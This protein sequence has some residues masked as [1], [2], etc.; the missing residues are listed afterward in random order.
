[1]NTR[2]SIFVA[3]ALT[4]SAIVITANSAI[5]VTASPSTLSDPT[6]SGDFIVSANGYI[7]G[8]GSC[9][10][11]QSAS[12]QAITGP[13][14]LSYSGSA[15]LISDGTGSIP[16]SN[17]TPGSTASGSFSFSQTPAPSLTMFGSAW[18]VPVNGAN[19]SVSV[20][21]A[22]LTYLMQITGPTPFASVQVDAHGSVTVSS[23]ATGGS[24]NNFAQVSF[25]IAGQFFDTALVNASEG[26]TTKTFNDTNTYVLATNY[27][28]SVQLYANLQAIVSGNSGGGTATFSGFIDPTFTVVGDNA[29]AYTLS[30]SPGIGNSV[31]AVPEPSTWAMMILGFGGLGFMAY[32]RRLN[33]TAFRIA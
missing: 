11:Q 13:G 24:T 4:T 33:G 12:H 17:Y 26:L 20:G 3:A 31:G 29:S 7:C 32:R 6:Y 2:H 8:G 9:S 30:F 1:M 10:A 18:T 5:A 14:S 23:I 28:Y 22:T 15:P 19:A 21:N 16:P 27:Q 25:G